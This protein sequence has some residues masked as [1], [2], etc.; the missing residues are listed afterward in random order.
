[1]SN[2]DCGA[3]PDAVASKG[4]KGKGGRSAKDAALVLRDTYW[5][6]RLKDHFPDQS[7]SSLE[8]NLWDGIKVGR[9]GEGQGYSQPFALAK[10]AAGTR[11]LSAYLDDVPPFVRKAGSLWPDSEAVYASC[12]W[13][14]LHS[15]AFMCKA[16]GQVTAACP[17]V[18][19]RLPA[20]PAD[21]NRW[22]PVPEAWVRRV[23]RLTH[24]D[25]LGLLL[26]AG[27]RHAGYYREAYLAN[28]Y[29]PAVFGRLCL[30]DPAFSAIAGGVRALIAEA[31]PDLPRVDDPAL[32]SAFAS[33]SGRVEDQM[34][35]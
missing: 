30:H 18:L 32:Q 27:S 35:F 33:R 19:K 24:L 11:G 31:Y 34:L 15:K 20:L 29:L 8:R 7:Y 4:L 10:V 26:F 6:R 3:Y 1:M 21:W 9:R 28:E 12:T 5:A 2:R 23:G 25:A 14:A 13:Q 16:L 17:E 22:H